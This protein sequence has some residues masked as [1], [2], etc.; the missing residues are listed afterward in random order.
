MEIHINGVGTEARLAIHHKNL[1]HSEKSE[2][3]LE[4]GIDQDYESKITRKQG[5][6]EQNKTSSQSDKVIRKQTEI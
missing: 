1:P 6:L 4:Q 2:I 5:N 3:T